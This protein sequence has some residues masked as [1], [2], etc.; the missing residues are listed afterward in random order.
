MGQSTTLESGSKVS[1]TGVDKMPNWGTENWQNLNCHALA[2]LGP[3]VTSML[4]LLGLAFSLSTLCELYVVI[5][6][7]LIII[8]I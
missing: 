7:R 6:S 2:N 5:V 1:E 4:R 3:F 8:T